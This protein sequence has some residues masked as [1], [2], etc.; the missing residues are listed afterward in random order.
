MINKIVLIG[1]GNLAT[2]FGKAFINAGKEIMQVYSRTERS[3]SELAGKLNCHYTTSLGK[4]SPGADLY[5]VAVTDSAIAEISKKI[6]LDNPLVA[7]TSGSTDIKVLKRK[8]IRPAVFYPLQTFSKD[9]EVDLYEVPL[10]LEAINNEDHEKLKNLAEIIS[11]KVYSID[12]KQRVM[13]H[14][15]AVFASNFTNHMLC[16]AE[17]LLRKNKMSFDILQPLINETFKKAALIGP[18]KAQTGPAA[19]NDKNILELH[20]EILSAFGDYRKFYNFMTKSI[21][22][23]YCKKREG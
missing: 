22:S 18:Y 9:T 16:I 20:S 10:F 13:L 7:H 19:R 8:N 1:A 5:I 12:S 4:L 17:E 6:K 3:A 14:I 15:A 21:I 23:K 11:S 2:H